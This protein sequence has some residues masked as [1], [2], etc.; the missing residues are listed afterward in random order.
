MFAVSAA[1]DAHDVTVGR[2]A[3]GWGL[4]GDGHLARFRSRRQRGDRPGP[5]NLGLKRRLVVRRLNLRHGLLVR[6]LN[7][8]HGLL[9]RRLN[10]RHGLLVRRLNLRHGLRRGLLLGLHA[11]LQRGQRSGHGALQLNRS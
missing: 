7:L 8:R 10:L 3:G 5:L 2:A 4:P 1:F 6:R 9:V 11:L